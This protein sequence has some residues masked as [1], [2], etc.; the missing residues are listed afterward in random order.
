MLGC[1]LF[2]RAIRAQPFQERGRWTVPISL[3][4]IGLVTLISF[5]VADFMRV[6]DKCFMSL[7]WFISDYAVGI[8]LVLVTYSASL[9]GIVIYIFIKL[10]KISNIEASERVNA[11]RMIYYL[12]LAVLSNAFI[13]PF[14]FVVGFLKTEW[15]EGPA[16]ALNLSMIAGVVASVTGL[17]TG[18]LHLFLRSSSI[19]TIGPRDKL[20]EQ[21]RAMLKNKI[22]LGAFNSSFDGNSPAGLGYGDTITYNYSNSTSYIKP[23]E[24]PVP[25]EHSETLPLSS[26][27]T[28]TIAYSQE[29]TPVQVPPPVQNGKGHFRKTSSYSLFPGKEKNTSMASMLLLPSTTYNPN[30]AASSRNSS[31]N[32]T[33]RLPARDHLGLRPPP[34]VLSNYTNHRRDSSMGSLATVQIG[35]RLS[36]VNDIPAID[37][38]ALEDKT[39]HYLE[40]PYAAQS[41]QKHQEPSERSNL[42]VPSFCNSDE[43]TV[44]ERESTVPNDL[45]RRDAI[46]DARMK[47]LPPVPTPTTKYKEEQPEKQPEE[48]QITLSPTV[49][50]PHS[51]SKANKLPSP[52]GVGFTSPPKR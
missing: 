23:V 46:K 41:R 33:L 9:L 51:P 7:F 40:C 52:R 36:N 19:S 12:S 5:L 8:F 13:C 49:Y 30:A 2:F 6:G 27:H 45:P 43:E 22:R 15:G 48:E 26:V 35:L 32:S 3:T 38:K 4:I 44:Y 24:L 17:M 11:S 16:S 20:E 31:R 28:N 37:P 14:F 25:S 29:A 1:E 10:T 18:G 50:I 42:H 21:E 47:T 34:S 39:I